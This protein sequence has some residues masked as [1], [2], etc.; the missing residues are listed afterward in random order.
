MLR[1]GLGKTSSWQARGRAGAPWL[2]VSSG[3]KRAGGTG[4]GHEG[5]GHCPTWVSESHKNPIE[6]FKKTETI[7]ICTSFT[8]DLRE[9]RLF[10]GGGQCRVE[11]KSSL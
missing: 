10:S 1:A 4:D 7:F 5:A 2:A 11:T 3:V 8:L 6:G 9:S